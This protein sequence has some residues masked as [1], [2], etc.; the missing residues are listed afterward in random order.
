MA[1]HALRKYSGL[2][3][4]L[5]ALVLVRV[6]ALDADTLPSLDWT[7]GIWT[8]EGFYTYHARNAILFGRG[9]LD[10]FH[11]Q[12]LSPILDW[13]Q[14]GVFAAFGVSLISARAISVVCSLFALG[15][16]FDAL[17]RTLGSRI[18][19][20][21][22]IFLGGDV[23]FVLYNRLALLETPSVLV[24]CAALW[25][26]TLKRPAGWLLA[27]ALAAS[28]VA[29]K[30]TFLIFLPVPLLVWG[31]RRERLYYAAGILSGFGLYLALWGIPHGVEV[32]RMNNYYR[33]H[34]SQPR[35]VGEA[36]ACAGRALFAPRRALLAFLETRT[37]VL[38]TLALLGLFCVR[39]K[40]RHGDMERVLWLWAV[41]GLVS[42]CFTRYAP[43]RYFL[44]IYP[45]FA[46]LA[47]ITLWR[48]IPLG[49][50]IRRDHR[51]R[52]RWIVPLFLVAY[53]TCGLALP[54]IAWAAALLLRRPRPR[55]FA[56]ATLALFL[57]ISLGQWGYWYAT[58]GY[59]TRD[60]AREIAGVVRPGEVLVGDWGPNLC[61]NNSVRAA[62]VFPTFAN[63]HSPMQ[64]LR[65]DYILVA[66]TPYPVAY[67]K[68]EAPNV[69]RPENIVR[70]VPFH[71]YLLVLYRVPKEARKEPTPP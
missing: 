39:W 29:F 41:L 68:R 40:R 22:L 62:P 61:L 7:S 3:L 24:L 60:V 12:L 23:V 66:Q 37:P 43:T 5:T 6:I 11:N 46:G 14:R 36:F 10:E 45:P 28:A 58:R 21:G 27:G 49:H 63:G 31:G 67:W 15:F 17:R 32:W 44:L 54:V 51:Q 52:A 55:V 65:P 71:D 2:I 70:R 35:S 50:W 59:R 19:L 18:A 8:D 64:T 25:A 20:T 38:T 1:C 48:L 30:T 42:L 16:F 53:H 9:D 34:Q 4:L 69:V 33:V 13:V 56:Q 47:A 57:T 26:L